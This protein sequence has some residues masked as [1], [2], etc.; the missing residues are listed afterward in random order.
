MV[1]DATTF[2]LVLMA[3]TAA[4]ATSLPPS[5][6]RLNTRVWRKKAPGKKKKARKRSQ[7]SKRRNRSKR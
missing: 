1:T 2:G 4:T 6:R 3:V 5:I 7:K